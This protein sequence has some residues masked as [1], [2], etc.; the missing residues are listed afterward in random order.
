MLALLVEYYKLIIPEHLNHHDKLFGGNTLKWIDEFAYITASL[1]FPGNNFL[2]IALDNVVF[3][4]AVCRGEIMR[5]V[6]T[7]NYLG[8]TSVQYNVRTFGTR[9][10]KDVDEVLFETKIT[11]VAVD[12]DGNKTP[13][14]TRTG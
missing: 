13:I 10:N 2:T 9:E 4:K 3:R 8:R 14:K 1:E 11:F 5:F 12:S 6:I 7:L